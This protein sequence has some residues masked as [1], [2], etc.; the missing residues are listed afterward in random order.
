M[1]YDEKTGE[2]SSRP[3]RVSL[4]KGHTEAFPGDITTAQGLFS[5]EGGLVFQDARFAA[6]N[7]SGLF[8]FAS[9]ASID[10]SD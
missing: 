3:L 2:T 9:W 5:V 6:S 10:A 8:W 4:P 1:I 7:R